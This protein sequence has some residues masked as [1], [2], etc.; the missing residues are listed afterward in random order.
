MFVKKQLLYV[1]MLLFY[2]Y[3]IVR[4]LLFYVKM[5]LFYNDIFVKKAAF[6]QKYLC[7]EKTALTS[8]AAVNN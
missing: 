6:E 5:L 7:V 1:K 2:N 4:K 8:T 3:P